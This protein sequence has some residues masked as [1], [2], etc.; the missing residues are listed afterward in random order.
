MLENM[1]EETLELRSSVLS[2]EEWT[3]KGCVWENR[4]R[5]QGYSKGV[6]ICYSITHSLKG[7]VQTY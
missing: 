3:G 5:K 7:S 1:E 4:E 2:V 6:F